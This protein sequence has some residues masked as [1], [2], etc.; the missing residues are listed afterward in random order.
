M[1]LATYN[2]QDLID[3]QLQNKHFITLSLIYNIFCQIVDGV[4]ALH[5]AG[6]V[7]GNLKLSNILIF[8]AGD[9]I[10]V[11]ITDYVGYPGSLTDHTADSM[12]KKSRH[13]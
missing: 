9:D 6:I 7:H 8:G 3:Q 13:I 1:Q 11:K 10:V 12:S 5:D 4:Q 2:L